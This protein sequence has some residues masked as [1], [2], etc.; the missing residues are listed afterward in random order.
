MKKVGIYSGS[1]NPIHIGHLALANYLC[2]F[3][4][5]DEIWFV[6]SPSN[7]WK[8][9]EQLLPDDFRLQLVSKSI[10]GYPHF[11]ASD[12]EF[13]LPQPSYTVRTLQELR[14]SYPDIR[15]SL[16][17][18]ADNWVKFK[19]WKDWQEIIAHHELYVYPRKGFAINDS[20]PQP[21]GVHI[22][23]SPILEISS[24]F[25]RQ[26]LEEGRDI[27]FFVHPNAWQYLRSIYPKFNN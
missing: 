10:A 14:N 25:I 2:E 24:T 5:F 12:I 22:V 18:G 19:Q 23:H 26:A 20:E 21:E 13:H 7:P 1:F 27:R 9:G 8:E 6:V 17:I 15:F 16:I 4:Q 3:E 11:K